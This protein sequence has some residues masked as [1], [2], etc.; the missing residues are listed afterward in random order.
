LIQ[1][2]NNMQDQ[3]L[4]GN[5]IKKSNIRF[6]LEI[7]ANLIKEQSRVLDIGCGDGSL[8]QHL[9]T[10]KQIDGRGIEIIQGDVSKA[11]AKGISV[12]QG[13]AETDLTYYPDASFD[14]AILSQT[15][16]ATKNPKEIIEQML[17]IAKFAIISFPNFAHYKNRLYFCLKGK[18]PVN[19]TIPYQWYDTPNIHFCS[20][21]D[22]EELCFN[23]NF[24]VQNRYYLTNKRKLDN[25][26][27]N[28]ILANVFAEY[29]LFLI[30]KNEIKLATEER[31]IL[32]PKPTT[33][34]KSFGFANCINSRAD[35]KTM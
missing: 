15:L 32:N 9:K 18:M 17:R 25:F 31:L 1:F 30:T 35:A 29:G 22:F 33:Y 28:R 11:L 26:V 21:K 14:Y 4:I 23:M 7:I 8:L 20:I 27:G 24:E 10:S 6:D 2:I 19:K 16:Q 34:Q 13:N 12:M 5:A 3:H